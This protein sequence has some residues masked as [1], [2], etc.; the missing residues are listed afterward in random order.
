M[1]NDV[2]RRPAKLRLPTGE[3]VK[4]Y[5][6]WEKW[7]N[8]RW[9][10][11]FLRR[12]TDFRDSCWNLPEEPTQRK[13]K[14]EEIAQ[15][16]H[17]K[18]FK[19]CDEKFGSNKQKKLRPNFNPL[20]AWWSVEEGEKRRPK[21]SIV[22]GQVLVRFDLRPAL[23]NKNLLKLQILYAQSILERQ[24]K[25]LLE[26]NPSNPTI[27]RFR[28]EN[29]ERKLQLLRMID[30]KASNRTAVDIYCM[31]HPGDKR[32]TFLP[33]ERDELRGKFESEYRTAKNWMEQGYL[34]LALK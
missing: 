3:D 9:G 27:K 16:F 12:N 34:M 5:K 21:A 11:E 6:G 32:D 26:I 4:E 19:H 20:D 28:D 25:R 8:R 29:A 15:R 18:K 30:L 23:E 13:I 22:E 7:S 31:I 33:G 1:T 14:E 17:L 10:W 2:A 24:F